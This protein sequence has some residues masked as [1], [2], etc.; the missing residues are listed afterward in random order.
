VQHGTANYDYGRLFVEVGLPRLLHPTL[1]GVRD[2]TLG[3]FGVLPLALI[4]FQL[5][6]LRAM[7]LRVAPFLVLVYAQLLFAVSERRL[8]ALAAPIMAL[9]AARAAQGLAARTRTATIQW[10]PLPLALLLLLLVEYDAIVAR[11]SHQLVAI[12]AG[13][14]LA[15]AAHL[16]VQR[17]ARQSTTP[18]APVT[19]VPAD[20]SGA[21]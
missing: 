8:I 14:V 3:V 10:L 1:A 6:E 13:A 20:G 4:A 17:F 2:N 9:L 15:V 16:L 18:A 7:L 19:S 5:R 11:T 21:R 12:A